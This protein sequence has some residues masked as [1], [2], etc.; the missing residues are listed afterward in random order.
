MCTAVGTPGKLSLTVTSAYDTSILYACKCI[1]MLV[2]SQYS[3][4]LKL[5]SCFFSAVYF[6][7]II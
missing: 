2:D 4:Q 6:I 3:K 5:E 1:F 7:V